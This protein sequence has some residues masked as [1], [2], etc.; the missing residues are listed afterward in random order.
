MQSDGILSD[1]VP[2][3]WRWFTVSCMVCTLEAGGNIFLTPSLPHE[4]TQTSTYSLLCPYL[5]YSTQTSTYSSLCPYL[6][7]IHRLVHTPHSVP[8]SCTVHRLVHTP[9][10]VPTSCTVHRLVLHIHLTMPP[11]VLYTD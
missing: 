8:T 2:V 10:F 6:M 4:H 9:H 1:E 11:S 3:F 7:N 5:M